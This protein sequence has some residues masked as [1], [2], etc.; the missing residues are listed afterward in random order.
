MTLFLKDIVEIGVGKKELRFNGINMVI[1]VS[2][3]G[4]V[5]AYL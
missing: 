4:R 1:S 2:I 3:K 5:Q